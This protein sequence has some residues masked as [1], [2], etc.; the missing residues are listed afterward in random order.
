MIDVFSPY[1]VIV[2]A[3]IKFSNFATHKTRNMKKY[4]ISRNIYSSSSDSYILVSYN[5]FE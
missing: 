2:R 5:E 4:Q 1:P 3:K